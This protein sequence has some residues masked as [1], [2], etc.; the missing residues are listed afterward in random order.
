[1]SNI[2]LREVRYW[3][4]E[5]MPHGG[6][7]QLGYIMDEAE[8]LMRH[9][10]ALMSFR[11]LQ[12]PVARHLAYYIFQSAVQARTVIRCA[13]EK[14]RNQQS[15]I[16]DDELDWR[17]LEDVMLD[18]EDL[19]EQL[20]EV[21]SLNQVGMFQTRCGVWTVN[22]S[23]L[24]MANELHRS[25]HNVDTHLYNLVRKRICEP[26]DVIPLQA[27]EAATLNLQ[28]EEVET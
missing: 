7:E 6:D 2:N 8:N 20:E 10:D 27:V 1:M 14:C 3:A 24:L 5:L 23:V 11:P 9:I 21:F 12:T 19:G 17:N 4:N 13:L 25:L 22:R 16:E 28:P 15:S 18:L 26:Y